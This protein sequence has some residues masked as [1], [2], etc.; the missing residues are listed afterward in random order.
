MVG[1]PPSKTAQGPIATHFRDGQLL[2]ELLHLLLQPDVRGLQLEGG[3]G[4]RQFG[5]QLLVALEDTG[6][7]RLELGK[8][9]LEFLDAQG[10]LLVL[11][12]SEEKYGEG[13][14]GVPGG[15]G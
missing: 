13:G 9:S 10:E 4:R 1:R 8:G 15:C 5:L 11:G 2:F 7:L 3:R 6:L 14:R 12:T